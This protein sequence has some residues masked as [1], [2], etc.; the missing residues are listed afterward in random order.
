MRPDG[1]LDVGDLARVLDDSAGPAPLALTA[2]GRRASRR[3][4]PRRGRRG[5]RREAEVGGVLGLREGCRRGRAPDRGVVRRAER[6]RGRGGRDELG[7]PRVDLEA[8]AVAQAVD[9]GASSLL[10]S[11]RMRA[12]GELADD[13]GEAREDDQRQARRGQRQAP[14]DREAGQAR[15]TY[16]APR[17]VCSRRGSPPASSL[18]RRLETKTSIVFVVANGS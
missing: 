13:D 12:D 17:M 9:R 7:R 8:D 4:S 5:A 3:G 18:R 11:E 2:A 10:K 1:V 16:P 6:R 14:P 15:R